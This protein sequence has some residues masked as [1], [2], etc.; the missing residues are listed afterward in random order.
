KLSENVTKITTPDFKELW[1]F[2]DK[3]TGK[4]MADLITCYGEEIDD[5]KPITIF[6][7]DHPYKKKTL[8][9]FTAKKLHVKIFDKGNCVYSSPTATEIRSF[10]AAQLDTLW[11][12][13]KRFENPHEYYVDLS[14]KLWDKKNELL[15][16][17]G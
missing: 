4:A 14:K 8:T 16:E 1:R 12:E 5:S 7:P 11:D 17:M 3:S 15:N 9:D 13:V 6:D 10:C 2:Y